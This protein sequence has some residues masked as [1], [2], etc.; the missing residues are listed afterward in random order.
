MIVFP[1]SRSYKSEGATLAVLVHFQ[2]SHHH[3]LSPRRIPPPPPPEGVALSE[4]GCL[5]LWV[6]GRGSVGL[7]QSRICTAMPHACGGWQVRT[8][9]C[10]HAEGRVLVPSLVCWQCLSSEGLVCGVIS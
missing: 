10:G 9:M 4:G 7:C 8:A 3:F 1:S 2:G 6:I 5:S